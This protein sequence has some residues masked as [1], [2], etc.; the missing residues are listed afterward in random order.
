MR[1]MRFRVGMHIGVI[2]RVCME[3]IYK[4]Y[5]KDPPSHSP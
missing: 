2:I 1:P 4:D 5:Y 3:I